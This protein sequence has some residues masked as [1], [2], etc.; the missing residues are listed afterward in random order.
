MLYRGDISLLNKP[1]FQKSVAVIGLTNPSADIIE[2]EKNIV[3]H[4]VKN[5]GNIVSSLAIGCDTIINQTCLDCSGK[6]I[7]VLPSRLDKIIPSENSEL[8]NKIVEKGGLII[9]EYYNEPFFLKKVII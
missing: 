3:K 4:I 6:T 1:N 9:T 7:A 2:R 8:A 5:G